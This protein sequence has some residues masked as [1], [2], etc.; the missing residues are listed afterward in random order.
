ME[1]LEKIVQ[2]Q[3]LLGD[4]LESGAA[5]KENFSKTEKLIAQEKFMDAET[6]DLLRK[7]LFNWIA[8]T[9]LCRDLYLEIFKEPLPEKFSDVEKILDAEEKRIR[10]ANIFRQ[11]GKFLLLTT[12]APDLK[13]ILREHQAEL[14]KLLARKRQ[15]AKLKAAVEP[16]SKFINATEEKNFGKKFSISNELREIFSDD[17]IGRGLFGNELTLLEADEFEEKKIIR[18][19][20][21]KI[22]PPEIE[23]PA[24]K[25]PPEEDDFTKILVDKGALLTEKDFAEW[26]KIFVVEK[27]DRNKDFSAV[28]FKRDFKNA[29]ILK[30]VLQYIASS[31]ILS[32]PAFCPKKMP[33]DIMES[34]AQ[35]LHN[36][37]YIQKY[38]FG[39]YGGFYGLT[40]NFFEFVKTD[41]GRKFVD[42]KRNKNDL[43]KIYFLAETMKFALIRTIYCRI[44][45]IEFDCGNNFSDVEFSPEAFR[46]EF[47]GKGKRDLLFG[48]FWDDAERSETFL[49]RQK[50]YFRRVGKYNRVFVAG[51]NLQHAQKMFDALKEIFAEDAPESDEFYLYDFAANE[52]YRKDTAEKISAED[53][54]NSS[55]PPEP[56]DDPKPEKKSDEPEKIS[57]PQKAA[58]PLLAADVKEKIL[59]D[60][61]SFLLDKKFYC[62]TAYLKAQSLEVKEAETLYRQLALALDDP[63]LGEGY[64][65]D[66]ISILAT[67]DDDDF[68]EA[69]I[70]AAAVRVLFY[71]DFGVDYGLV[72]SNAALAE[73]IGDLKNFKTK[74]MK[75]V[76]FYADYRM[77]DRLAA[78]E[79]LAKVIRSAEDYSLIFD[80]RQ[81]DKAYNKTF[82]KLKKILFSRDGDLGQIFNAIKDKDEAHSE[83]TLN[84]I[85]DFLAEI[86]LKKD[87]DFTP[88]NIDAEK[89]NQFIADKWNEVCDKK[90]PGKLTGELENRLCVRGS[91]VR[92]F[93]LRA[94]KTAAVSSIKKFVRGFWETFS[95]RGK[96]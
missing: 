78:E 87:A 82:I 20:R 45:A 52:F 46:L 13:K 4:W 68:N 55:P 84:F 51:L 25:T 32:R 8:G 95:R 86:F 16:Y 3:K 14:K 91:T 15:N 40:R 75:G 29:E 77:K 81:T 34:I 74:V 1:K 43:E 66:A 94:A 96:I 89:L 62:A 57:V 70:T 50:N 23:T 63:L 54:W 39:E 28:R 90:N 10:E 49:K 47:V 30:P 76:D 79:N 2:L 65:A 33:K 85:K 6:I 92:K 42:M 80:G 36:K 73:L 18:R 64:S 61:K 21:R 83:D 26:K 71:N 27:N 41:S 22:S 60:V 9:N 35:L 11:A 93:S 48:C 88:V 38:S 24:P 56:E 53:I 44:Y 12:T 59:G 5:L 58:A 37:G 67:Q 72:N 31:G 7:N 19:R 69:L 17:L